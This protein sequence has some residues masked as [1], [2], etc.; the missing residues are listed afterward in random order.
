MLNPLFDGIR[1]KR[2]PA[3]CLYEGRTFLWTFIL[4]FL[5]RMGSRNS[6]DALRNDERWAGAVHKLA[7]QGWWVEG[8][9]RTAPC[10]LS[11]CNYLSRG[12]T[13]VLEKALVDIVTHMMRLKMFDGARFRGMFAVA[14]DGTKQER[15]RC[16]RWLGNRANRYVLEAKLVT[17]WGSAYSIMSVP[18]KPWHDGDEDGKQDSEYHGFLRLAP[19]LKAAFPHLGM[20]ILG[21]GLYACAPLMELCEKYGWDYIFTFKEGRTPRAYADARGLMEQNPSNSGRLVRHDSRGRR[22]VCGVVAW[23]T[24]VEITR[25]ADQWHVFNVVKVAEDDSNGS[26]YSGQFATS[27]EVRDEKEADSIGKWGRRRWDIE[28]SFYVEKNGGYGLE[29]NFC[30]KARTSRNIYLLMQIAHNLWQLFNSG[31]LLP[32]QKKEKY[33]NMTQVK[34]AELIRYTIMR[35]GIVLSLDEIPRRYISREFLT[36]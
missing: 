22:V 1:K 25:G 16:C 3:K 18:L 26:P 23:A 27:L 13:A 12:C 33:R 19:M 17:P 24:G 32:M 28:S 36:L 29:H 11:V 4:G 10:S 21:D 9:R 31:C 20:C 15:I 35:V 8:E 7:G 6:I 30:N 5:G 14:V 34:W 2:D